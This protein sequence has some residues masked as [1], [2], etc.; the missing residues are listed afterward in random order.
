MIIMDFDKGLKVIKDL[1]V[2]VSLVCYYVVKDWYFTEKLVSALTKIELMM[3][4]VG[5]Q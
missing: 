4:S 1:G 3:K 2:P 5:V